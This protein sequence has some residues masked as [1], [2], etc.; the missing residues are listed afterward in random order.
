MYNYLRSMTSEY[1]TKLDEFLNRLINNQYIFELTK[2]CG[3]GFFMTFYKNYT[4]EEVYV[5]VEKEM[6]HM[7]VQLYLKHPADGNRIDIPRDSTPLRQFI[8]NNPILFIPL[9]PMPYK[10]VYKIYY[11]DGHD[12]EHMEA[13]RK[14]GDVVQKNNDDNV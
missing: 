1:Q 2:C 9:Y 3:Y 12:H 6:P 13:H 4:L 11:D 14:A 5:A 10:V 8:L 7:P